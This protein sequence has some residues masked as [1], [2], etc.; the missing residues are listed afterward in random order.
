MLTAQLRH[1][2][3]GLDAF[4]LTPD[5]PLPDDVPTLQTLVRELLA[6]VARLR[7]DN[8]ALHGKLDAALQQRFGRRSERIAPVANKD[9]PGQAAPH[10]RAP[11]P[12]DL[13]T[14]RTIPSDALL[15]EL[16]SAIHG[17]E[18][19]RAARPVEEGDGQVG[20][21]EQRIHRPRVH[22][23]DVGAEAGSLQRLRN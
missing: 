22:V 4:S 20:P 21:V 11:L 5:A 23:L 17:N 3:T 12:E 18:Q 14:V 13:E 2:E 6:E 7:A 9:K 8:D 19:S 1:R 16:E 15:R 10:G